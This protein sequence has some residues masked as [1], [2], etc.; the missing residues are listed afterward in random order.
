M[1][2]LQCHDL[3]ECIERVKVEDEIGPLCIAIRRF[4]AFEV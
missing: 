2:C 4:M 1:C 3:S